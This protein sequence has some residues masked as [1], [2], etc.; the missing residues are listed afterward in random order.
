MLEHKF[1]VV[2]R[3]A[4]F[5]SMIGIHFLVVTDTAAQYSLDF[6]E[7][8]DGSSGLKILRKAGTHGYPYYIIE[9]DLRRAEIHSAFAPVDV[10]RSAI[11]LPDNGSFGGFSP[12]FKR[13]DLRDFRRS[14]TKFPIA[15][16]NGMFFGKVTAYSGQVAFPVKSSGDILT[17]GYG[18][19]GGPEAEGPESDFRVLCVDND[20]DRANVC[21]YFR[22][23]DPSAPTDP[24][25]PCTS[26]RCDEELVS[27]SKDVPK[28]SHVDSRT[29]VGVRDS[30]IVMVFVSTAATRDE[31]HMELIARGA[32]DTIQLDGGGSTQFNLKHER[33]VKSTDGNV[34]N[35]RLVPHAL[36]VTAQCDFYD[37][38]YGTWFTGFIRELC[39]KDIVQGYPDEKLRPDSEV[40]RVE[41]LKIMLEG[42]KVS[43]VLRDADFGLP[44][45]DPFPDV[46]A[47]EWYAGYVAYAKDNGVADGFPDGTFRPALPVTRAESVKM[48]MR[49]NPSLSSYYDDVYL[50]KEHACRKH[51]IC[52]RVDVEFVDVVNPDVLAE[53][54]WYYYYVYAAR[55]KEI[56]NGNPDGRFLPLKHLN[57][58][59]AGKIVWCSAFGGDGCG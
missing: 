23:D 33:V 57:R 59:E 41:F 54:G 35:V 55:D 14:G 49:A 12:V 7:L 46:D 27:F 30:S 8:A 31:A 44:E 9:V 21:P 15:V 2:R 43:G 6:V 34:E 13:E 19:P 56:V 32:L 1:E 45:T 47:G 37:F 58:A 42:M 4:M 36:A 29:F 38:I 26:N 25:N 20:E 24:A 48:I 52:E 16:T 50:P 5:V 39:S 3:L 18:A 22:I 10:Q 17:E 11:Q 51:R 53:D 28:G 40:N